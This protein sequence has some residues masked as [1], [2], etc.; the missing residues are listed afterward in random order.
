MAV[1]NLATMAQGL[2]R[3]Y[4]RLQGRRGAKENCRFSSYHLSNACMVDG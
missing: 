1:K 4:K 3:L 2:M